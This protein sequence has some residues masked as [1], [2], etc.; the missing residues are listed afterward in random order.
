M[1]ASRGRKGRHLR[2]CRGWWIERQRDGRKMRRM[3]CGWEGPHKVGAEK[4]VRA[5]K[6]HLL[7]SVS[8]RLQHCCNHGNLKEINTLHEHFSVE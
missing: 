4:R 7:C 8:S 6:R 2:I 3:E 1:R 5:E